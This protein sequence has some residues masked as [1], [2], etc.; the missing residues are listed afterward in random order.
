MANWQR[1]REAYAAG[2]GTYAQLARKYNVNLSTLQKRANREGWTSDLQRV[3]NEVAT[4]LPHRIADSLLGEAERR[5]R[6]QLA[7]VDR[8]RGFLAASTPDGPAEI[9]HWVRA[10]RGVADLERLALNIPP[11]AHERREPE[12]PIIPGQ[13]S[14]ETPPSPVAPATPEPPPQREPRDPKESLRLYREGLG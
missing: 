12:P 13:G 10:A 5:A 4:G 1:I 8:A 7:D 6:L 14:V 3:C 9:G 11:P 2:K